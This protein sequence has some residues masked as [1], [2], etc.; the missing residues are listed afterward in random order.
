MMVPRATASDNNSRAPPAV[1]AS[2]TGGIDTSTAAKPPTA[3]KPMMPM[4]NKP[5]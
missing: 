3:T 5:A 2:L 1:Q 4:L